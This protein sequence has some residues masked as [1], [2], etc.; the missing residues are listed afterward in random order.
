MNPDMS[1]KHGFHPDGKS[2]MNVLR[3]GRFHDRKDGKVLVIGGGIAGMEASLN[4]VEAGYRVSLVDERPNI[5]GTM[6][7][8]DK[9]F[10]TND[11]SMC[12]MAP[13]LVEVDVILI[14]SFS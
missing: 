10:P 4:L 2:G 11:C 13:K 12:I 5:G 1:L 6:A 8:L 14:L 9:T 7:K 3:D